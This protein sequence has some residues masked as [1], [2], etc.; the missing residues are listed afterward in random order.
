NGHGHTGHFWQIKFTPE[1]MSRS[2]AIERTRA[3]L[4]DSIAH[5]FVS[6]VPVGIFLSGGVDSTAILALARASQTNTLRTY[7]IAF[8]ED[9]VNEGPVACRT[10]ERFETDHYEH[11]ITE[12]EGRSL[13]ATFREHVDQPTIDGF[14]SY[15]VSKVARDH[16]TKVCLSGLG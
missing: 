2:E 6:D 7:S 5:H 8:E 1:E 16:G 11:L 14:N 12:A 10:A 9:D 13:M 3:A 4:L 15:C